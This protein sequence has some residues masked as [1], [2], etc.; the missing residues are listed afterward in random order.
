MIM[1]AAQ[2]ITRL[3]EKLTENT[4]DGFI[5][6]RAD[7]F[8]G[9]FV[10]SYAERLKWLTDFTG[11]AGAAIVLKDKAAVLSDGRYTIQLKQQIDLKIFEAA[12]S[13]KLGI[14]GWLAVNA[15]EGARIGFDPHLH[16]QAQ[17]EK[18][19]AALTGRD[20]HFVS[21]VNLIDQ[22]WEDQPGKPLGAVEIFPLS[23]AGKSSADKIKDI[24]AA[25]AKQGH[26]ACV[27]TL[28][29]SVCWLLNVRGNDVEHLPVVLSTAIIY[30][31][32]RVRWVVDE[33]KV[34]DEVRKHIGAVEIVNPDSQEQLLAQL[35]LESDKPIMLDANHAALWFKQQLHANGAAVIDAKDP[36]IIPKAIKTPEEIESIRKAHLLDGAAIVKFLRW[37]EQQNDVASLSEI[38]VEEKLRACRAQH[39]SFRDDSFSTIAGFGANGAIVHYRA[40]EKTNAR[41]SDNNLLLLDSGGQYLSDNMGGTTDI[42]RTMA[43]G[44]P[45]TEMCERFTQVLK[46]HIAVARAKFPEG[47]TGIEI[48]ARARKPLHEAGIDY[49]H[50]TG[51]G[52]GCYLSVHEEAASISPR[53]ADALQAGMLLSNEPGYYKEGEY[54]IRIENLVFIRKETDGQLG[55]E[56]VSLVPIDRTLIVRSLLNADELAWINEYHAEVYKRITPLLDGDHAQ[57]LA[58]KT[59]PL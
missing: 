14:G 25:I 40:S 43:I 5:V 9:E 6:P 53:G 42:T 54:G 47:T 1:N 22:I 16:T 7:E 21:C 3:R 38:G 4:L 46:G 48:D 56:T 24:S 13:V 34:S 18:I 29:D 32:G 51:H 37:L 15:P 11:S 52:V 36:C 12:D 17:I 8:Q 41:F 26:Y 44:K 23:V 39:K 58:E 20:V 28:P 33:R 49:M 2:K 30:A 19:E 45:T 31:D 57:W 59:A 55:F 35:A 27:L 50:G 10:S